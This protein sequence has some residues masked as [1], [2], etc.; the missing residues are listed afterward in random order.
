MNEIGFIYKGLTVFLR[1]QAFAGKKA[2]C[3][4]IHIVITL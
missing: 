4:Y 1:M 3:T 2:V